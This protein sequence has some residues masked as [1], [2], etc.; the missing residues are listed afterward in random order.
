LKSIHEIINRQYYKKSTWI[1]LLLPLSFIY[2]LLI[3]IRIWAYKTGI[4]KST[5]INVP[6]VV[7][8]NITIGGTGKTPAVLW[9][10]K[11]LVK[12]GMKPGLIS[13]GYNSN[14]SSPQEV[15]IDSL[16]SDV[17]DEAL[18]IKSR[19]QKNNVPVFVGKRRAKVAKSLL[20]YYPDV[21]ILISDDGLQHYELERDFE[22]VVVDGD[23]GYGNN[24]LM[25][26][27]PLREPVSRID[28]VDAVVING[29]PT[30]QLHEKNIISY[31]MKSRGDL[32]VN[33]LHENRISDPNALEKDIIAVTGIGNP[34]RFKDHLS[35]LNIH[36]NKMIIFDDHHSFTKADFNDYDNVDVIMTE[37]DAVK[38]KD[39]AKENFWYLPIFS[40]VEEKLFKKILEKLRLN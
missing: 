3:S 20:N 7:V 39:F 25:P 38:C 29:L 5:K 40:S 17:G 34:Q 15:F 11:K 8:G 32:L 31:Q 26:A 14:A 27:G 36:L 22:I 10:L 37:K 16:V 9:L 35:G 1:L 24:F 6:V 33:C 28:K 21:N 30:K 4:L 13:R 19:F 23:R 2:F 18:M 12:F